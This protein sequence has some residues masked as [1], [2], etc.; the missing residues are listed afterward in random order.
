MYNF[1]AFA[2]TKNLS[3]I[4]PQVIYKAWSFNVG[5]KSTGFENFTGIDKIPANT[6]SYSRPP[7]K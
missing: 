6:G 5:P 7:R 1:I 2:F 3:A 4:L